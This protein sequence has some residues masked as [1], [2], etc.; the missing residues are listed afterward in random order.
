LADRFDP[1]KDAENV[2]RHGISLARFEAITLERVRYSPKYGEDRWIGFGPLDG[3]LHALVFTLRDGERRPI[4][5]RRA[6]RR[7]RKEHARHA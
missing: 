4:S 7:E 1:A 6:S 5:L 2:R 3:K